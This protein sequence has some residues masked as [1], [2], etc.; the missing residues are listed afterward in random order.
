MVSLIYGE[1]SFA[2]SL[3]ISLPQITFQTSLNSHIIYIRKELSALKFVFIINL[4][5]SD[6]S[7]R[8]IHEIN[9]VDLRNDITLEAGG[10]TISRIFNLITQ[11]SSNFP[12][13]MLQF[14]R[15]YSLLPQLTDLMTNHTCSTNSKFFRETF[16]AFDI[17]TRI[18]GC[19]VS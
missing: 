15:Q 13:E 4:Q 2:S 5:G 18:L 6:S 19:D 11:N 17:V 12:S 3:S 14:H 10:S 7:L 9:F 8:L 16:D 1:P